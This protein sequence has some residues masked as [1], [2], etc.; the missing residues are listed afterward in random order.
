MDA[1]LCVQPGTQQ[2]QIRT[3]L[4]DKEIFMVSPII[5]RRWL[6]AVIGLSV[7]PKLIDALL[8]EKSLIGVVGIRLTFKNISQLNELPLG[9]KISPLCSCF[10]NLSKIGFICKIF[11]LMSDQNRNFSC[12]PTRTI[13]N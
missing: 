9:I 8:I 11:T 2:V 3:E 7:Y 6:P 4:F 13:Y 12:Q 10:S 5:H 1:L